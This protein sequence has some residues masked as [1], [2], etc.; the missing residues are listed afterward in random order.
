[1]KTPVFLLLT[2][3]LCVAV[4][5][6]A[7]SASSANPLEGLATLKDFKA[8]RASSSDPNWRDG[9]ADFR[10][11]PP[12]ETLTL[13]E[14]VGPGQIAHIWFTISARDQ[15]YSKLLTLRMY[16]DG[17]RNPSV[18]CPIG[19]FFAAGHG[20]DVNVTSIPVKVS[21]DG[22]GRNCYWPMPFRKS[23][24]ITV[25]NDGFQHVGS[26]YYYIDWQAKKSLPPDTA[27]FHAQY[28]QE[29]PCK[30]G[31]NYLILDAVGKG[32]YVGTVQS[33]RLSEPGWYG[34]GDDFFFIDGEKEPSLRG[35]GTEDYFCDGWGFRKFD[36]PFYGVPI[37]EGFATGNRSTV[38]RWHLTDPIPF[39]RSLRVEIEHKGS[40]NNVSGFIERADDFS[41]V[42]Y[43]YQTEPHKRFA[44]APPGPERLEYDPR[45]M[46]QLESLLE[47]ATSTPAGALSVQGGQ[48]SGQGQLWFR[49]DAQG[50][51]VTVPISVKDSGTFEL[52]LFATASWDYGIYQAS[53]D[54][55]DLGRPMDFLNDAPVGRQV[56]LGRIELAAGEHSLKFRNTGKNEKSKGYFLG[57]DG[58]ILKPVQGL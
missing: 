27:Y 33:V 39:T 13:A 21:S 58:V 45:T 28:R 46:I 38:Y 54:G 40:R 56:P 10:P 22:R 4:A 5:L 53:L 15:Y 50:G 52:V 34:E 14:L 18:E 47:K 55:K 23:A 17:E 8:M 51:E 2:I 11:I 44:S 43:W 30:P 26:F 1:M 32:H 20:L 9:N 57:L 16:W 19:D 12:G 31:Q 7:L 36:G 37:F 24:R 35:T 25:T 3:A 42:A 29:Y 6:P 41:T 49:P 48:G